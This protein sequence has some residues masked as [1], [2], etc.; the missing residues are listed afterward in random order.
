MLLPLK[1]IKRYLLSISL[2]AKIIGMVV[3]LTLFMGTVLSLQ[4]S[5]YLNDHTVAF[6]EQESKSMANE[7]AYKVPD[8]ILINDLYGLTRFLNSTRE[9]RRDIRYMIVIDA[10]G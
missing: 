10:Q 9:N 1:K 8:Y 5:R 3:G 2:Q 7:L 4:V 6:M